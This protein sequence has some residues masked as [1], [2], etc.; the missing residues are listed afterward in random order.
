MIPFIPIYIYY[1]NNIGDRGG[2]S[3]I[4]DN[5]VFAFFTAVIF[6]PI[7][8]TFLNQLAVIRLGEDFLKIKNKYIL[9]LLSALVFGL[10]HYYSLIYIFQTFLI[11]LIL[12]YSFIL[13]DDTKHSAFWIV[14]IIHALKNFVAIIVSFFF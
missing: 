10:G 4:G 9:V 12:A 13:Y 2:P 3:F 1:T 11:G 6:A 14:T 8:E 7:F 5:F